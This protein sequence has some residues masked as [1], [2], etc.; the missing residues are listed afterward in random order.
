[1]PL[2]WSDIKSRSHTFSKTWATASSEAKP[3]LI[4]FFE[5]FG[6]TNKHLATFEHAVKKYG[7]KQGFVDLFWMGMLLVEMN[8]RGMQMLKKEGLLL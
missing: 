3:F 7:C 1:M 8:S 2:S 4:D 6:I 5:V